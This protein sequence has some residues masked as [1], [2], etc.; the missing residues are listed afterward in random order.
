MGGRS[1]G[2]VGEEF[3]GWD[4]FGLWERKEEWDWMGWGGMGVGGHTDRQT[5]KQTNGLGL[6]KHYSKIVPIRVLFVAQQM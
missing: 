2:K 4:I 3:W 1:W 5:D 6:S